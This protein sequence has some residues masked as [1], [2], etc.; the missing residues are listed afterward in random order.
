MQKRC[1]DWAGV[2]FVDCIFAPIEVSAQTNGC[3]T[4]SRGQ[5]SNSDRITVENSYYIQ[6]LGTMQGEM[7][8]TTPPA[9]VTYV[10][11]TSAGVKVYVRKTLVTNVAATAISANAATI[12]WTGFG[13]RYNLRYSEGGLAKVTLSVPND[14]WDDGTGYQML[15]NKD[16]NTFGPVNIYTAEK[17]NLYLG[18]D[19]TLHYPWAE[20]MTFFNVNACRA[21]FHLKNGLTAGEPT[22]QSESGIRAFVLNF[23]DSSEQTGIKETIY[24]TPGSTSAWEG[25]AEEWYSLDGRRINGK[26]TARGIYINNN[27]KIVIK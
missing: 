14:I 16:H 22:S 25:S 20:G 27:R 18:A 24:P 6:S 5:N 8:Y 13:D 2:K 12:R 11:M 26:P 10:T 7:A 19:N 17:T 21:Y 9:N 23:G 3:A 15:L 4:F 1:H